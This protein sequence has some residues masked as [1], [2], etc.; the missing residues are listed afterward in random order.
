MARRS[1]G[2]PWAVRMNVSDV[3]AVVRKFIT[4]EAGHSTVSVS[5]LEADQNSQK[6]KVLVDIGGI[7]IAHKE[8]VVDDRDG[9][10]ISYRQATGT[11]FR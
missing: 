3:I 6:W 7:S 11:G 5:S 2:A 1:H 10:V 4:E 9:K 8:V